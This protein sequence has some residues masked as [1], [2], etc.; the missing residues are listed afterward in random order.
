MVNEILWPY[1]PSQVQQLVGYCPQFDALIEKMTVIE[2]LRMYA[3]LRGVPEDSI[4]DV[5]ASLIDKLL[6]DEYTDKLAGN[7]RLD[8]FP[9]AAL[10][11]SFIMV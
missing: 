9:Y 5:V 2:T 10:S 6:L 3:R 1:A 8:R 11:I 4:A 7:L